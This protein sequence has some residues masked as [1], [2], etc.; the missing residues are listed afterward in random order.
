MTNKK[1]VTKLVHT[2][3]WHRQIINGFL[4]LNLFKTTRYIYVKQYK[5]IHIHKPITLRGHTD[6]TMGH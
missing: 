1:E 2:V 6:K 4:G 5:N 3:Y